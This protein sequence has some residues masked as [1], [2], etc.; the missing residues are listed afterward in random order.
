MPTKLSLRHIHGALGLALLLTCATAA[1]ANNHLKPYSGGNVTGA[2]FRGTKPDDTTLSAEI[3]TSVNAAYSGSTC[4][5]AMGSRVCTPTKVTVTAVMDRDQ[6]W[7][8]DPTDKDL[9]EHEQGHMDEAEQA[10]RKAQAEIDKKL[11]DGTLKGEGKT[12]A[13]AK[14]DLDR[15]LRAITERNKKA[16]E[17]A[18]GDGKNDYDEATDHGTKDKEQAEAR[19]RQ[20]DALK[21]PSTDPQN[22][23]GPEAQSRTEKS[24]HFDAD[25]S[26]LDIDADF[27]VGT[28]P[29][30]GPYAADLLDRVLGAEVIVPTFKLA[31]QTA[32]GLFFFTAASDQGDNRLRIA[33][34]RGDLLTADLSYLLYDP[35]LNLFFALAGSLAADPGLS[36]FIDQ[37]L[38]T[39]LGDQLALVGIEW[40]PDVDFFAAS[41]GFGID[42]DAPATNFVGLRV[43]GLQVPLPGTLWLLLAALVVGIG[44]GGGASARGRWPAVNSKAHASRG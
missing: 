25:T 27:I 32:A 10:A 23:K 38:A 14:A 40:K 21:A 6:S 34:A 39:P 5:G 8:D 41:N 13:E 29:P 9:V 26:E 3:F 37:L 36:A 12:D 4:S 44:G 11:K 15:K 17:D 33:D 1:W 18:N 43:V 31:G 19:K 28:G 20:T 7:I 35:E 30:G 24:I 42:A 16:V 22:K 2:D